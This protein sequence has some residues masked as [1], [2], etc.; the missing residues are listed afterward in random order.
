[1]QRRFDQKLCPKFET[2]MEILSRPW[3]GLLIASLTAGPHRFGELS[4]RLAPIGDRILSQRLKELEA[5]G[6]VERRVL[7]GP[8][9][10][11]EYTLTQA[12]RGFSGVQEA[13][14]DWG[15]TI[16]AA[17]PKKKARRAKKAA[18]R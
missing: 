13:I 6:L 15:E 3:N 1:M 12:G 11:V 2:A 14:R 8:P 9:V 5:R 4:E 7:P 18:S 17:L 16:D 10:R